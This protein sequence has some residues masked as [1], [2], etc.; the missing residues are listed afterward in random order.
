[1]DVKVGA[2]LTQGLD[3]GPQVELT[4]ACGR[5]RRQVERK[6]AGA[7]V[8]VPREAVTQGMVETVAGAV[9]GKVTSGL[10]RTSDATC[11]LERVGATDCEQRGGDEE[12][13][14]E[15]QRQHRAI[16]SIVKIVK[17]LS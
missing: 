13:K 8:G 3:V 2:S 17:V 15:R 10:G 14:E 6:C 1:M 9:G 12:E 16:P 11:G 4:S 7:V 5:W